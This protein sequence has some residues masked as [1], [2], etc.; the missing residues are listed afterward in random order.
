MMAEERRVITTPWVRRALAALALLAYPHLVPEFWVVSIGAHA[1]VLG[2]IAL[3]MTF[4]AAYGGMISLA[5]MA[6][7]GVAGYTLAIFSAHAANPGASLPDWPWAVLAA[8]CAGTAA[9]LL[10][11]AIAVRS[12]G[13]YMLMST[14]AISM[15]LFYFTQQNTEVFHGFDGFRG[16]TIPSVV[17]ESLRGPLAFY[18]LCLAAGVVLYALVG[19]LAKT[20]FGLA[21]QGI[22]DDPQ[23]M[24]SLGYRVGF[25]QI[26]A[27]GVAGF[28]AAVGGVLSLWYNGGISPG[29]IGMTATVNILIV[30]VIGGLGHP[31]GAFVGAVAF[32]L[33]QNFAV[34]LVGSDRFNTLIGFVFLFIVMASPDGVTGLWQ[35]LRSRGTSLKAEGIVTQRL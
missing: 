1:F 15:I 22:R 21:I 33:I 10:I 18:H 2:I 23:R 8:L 11:G 35:R 26:M 24:A 20:P 5:Q 27:F 17:G 4:L 7:A 25:H 6:T 32:V 34:D 19:Y 12:R 29:S 31:R 28:I 16:V 30:A 14:L 9:G 3:S 13:I